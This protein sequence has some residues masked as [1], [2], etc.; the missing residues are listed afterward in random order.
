MAFTQVEWR[1]RRKQCHKG[2]DIGHPEHAR[3][4]SRVL[5]DSKSLFPPPSLLEN[6]RICYHLKAGQIL[7]AHGGFAHYGFST[8]AGETHSFACNIMTEQW[9]LSGGPEFVGGFFEWILQLHEIPEKQLSRH[10]AALGME[11]Q[12]VN[13]L[14]LCPPA[15]TCSL[16]DDLRKALEKHVSSTSGSFKGSSFHL[17]VHTHSGAS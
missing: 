8:D 4:L 11:N 2:D 9:L 16:L 17:C 13:A 1:R 10:L 7:I 14:N 3:V 15:Y 6:H 5:R 12:L